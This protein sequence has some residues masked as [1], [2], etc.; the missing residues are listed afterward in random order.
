M[1]PK[2]PWAI[3]SGAALVSIGTTIAN[4]NHVFNGHV[5]WMYYCYAAGIC[6]FLVALILPFIP[7]GHVSPRI[8]ATSYGRAELGTG[9]HSRGY[10]TGESGLI[11]ANDGE[12]AYEVGVYRPFVEF[13]KEFRLH[14]NNRIPRLRK[15]D[16]EGQ[17]STWIEKTRGSILA[18]GLFDFMRVNNIEQ[19]KVP[20]HYKDIHNRWY[21]TICT[22]TR[23]VVHSRDGLVVTSNF[24][25]RA[26]KP[27]TQ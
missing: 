2:I 12:P 26:W 6:L 27:R 18:N 3:A 1:N 22:I 24:K 17:I 20:V 25:G 11:F 7:T 9:L 14:F 10:Q 15:E 8:V 23:D 4:A 16:G 13:G 21:K 19:V 5:H